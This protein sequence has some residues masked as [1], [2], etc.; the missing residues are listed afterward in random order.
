MKVS[1]KQVVKWQVFRRVSEGLETW[2]VDQEG[3]VFDND[4]DAYKR[5]DELDASIPQSWGWH[6]VRA[7]DE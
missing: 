6:G 5:A 4:V 1:K 3:E 7:I 2:D